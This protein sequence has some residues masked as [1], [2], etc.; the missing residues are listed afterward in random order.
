MQVEFMTGSELNQATRSYSYD[1]YKKYCMLWFSN[2]GVAIN[3]IKDYFLCGFEFDD[4]AFRNLFAFRFSIA[5][6][7]INS[8][9]DEA[10]VWKIAA[11]SLSGDFI[12]PRDN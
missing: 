5:C 11:K 2:G 1:A 4:D 12:D 9:N 7:Q 8:Q 6:V 10:P 3:E